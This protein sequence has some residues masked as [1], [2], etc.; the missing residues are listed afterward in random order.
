M[1]VKKCF[2]NTENAIETAY[3]MVCVDIGGEYSEATGLC[4]FYPSPMDSTITSNV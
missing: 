4:D 2:N 1:K 3:E